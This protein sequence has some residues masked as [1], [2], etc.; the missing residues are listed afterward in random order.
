MH[1]QKPR[2]P[3]AANTRIAV[4]AVLGLATLNP[5]NAQL[6]CSGVTSPPC[7]LTQAYAGPSNDAN[8]NSRQG[9]N[10]Y[11]TT[12][13]PTALSSLPTTHQL[14]LE[15]DD[16]SSALP[17]SGAPSN[18]IMAEPLYVKGITVSSPQQGSCSPCNMII[19][20]TL[21]GTVFAWVADGSSAGNKL[22]SRQGTGSNTHGGNGFHLR[23]PYLKQSPCFMVLAK[24][25]IHGA[26]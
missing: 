10:L 8:F 16:T 14:F 15:V 13:T 23:K 25:P 1:L 2:T 26:L 5:L 12:L 11:E 22:W 21:N 18:P 9:V 3:S 19:A 7:V 17:V 4:V 6:C 20:V 24:C